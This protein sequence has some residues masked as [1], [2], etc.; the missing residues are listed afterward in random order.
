MP[1]I[2]DLTPAQAQAMRLGEILQKNPDIAMRAKRLA[3]EADPTLRIPEVELE[4]KIAQ[5]TKDAAKRIDDLEQRQIA[6]EVAQ[7]REQFRAV[8]KEQGLDP[9]EVEKIV[10]DEKCSTGTAIKLAIASRQTGEASAAEVAAGSNGQGSPIEV[11]PDAEWRKLGGNL[12]QLRRKS[13]DVAHEM[14]NT[15]RKGTRRSA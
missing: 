3:K 11:R 5:G 12:A 9:A 4:D 10:V 2:E 8:C 1:G 6:N 13:A 14:V 15:F 7:R